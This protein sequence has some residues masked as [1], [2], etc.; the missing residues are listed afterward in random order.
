VLA[1]EKKVPTITDNEKQMLI[2]TLPGGQIFLMRTDQTG[3]FVRAG[4]FDYLDQQDPALQATGLDTLDLL[5]SRGLVRHEA[6]Q[7]Y[8]LTGTGF[9]EARRLQV[10]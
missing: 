4:N 10:P 9:E 8:K 5:R 2:H 3:N 7:L 6:G 1:K